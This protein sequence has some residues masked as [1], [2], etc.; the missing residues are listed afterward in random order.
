MSTD[1]FSLSRQ[2][3]LPLCGF[4]MNG[5]PLMPLVSNEQ[6]RRPSPSSQLAL[7]R[8]THQYWRCLGHRDASPVFLRRS[9]QTPPRSN[10]TAG[11]STIVDYSNYRWHPKNCSATAIALFSAFALSIQVLVGEIPVD[12]CP[13]CFHIRRALIAIINIVSVLPHIHS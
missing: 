4:L 10:G 8:V 1:T 12:Q 3:T 13:K 11:E 2:D 7:I 5:S 6:G 9:G